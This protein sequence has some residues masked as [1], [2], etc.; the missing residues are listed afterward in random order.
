MIVFN[1]SYG[2][3]TYVYIILHMITA[4]VWIIQSTWRNSQSIKYFPS[5]RTNSETDMFIAV[6]EARSTCM[7]VARKVMSRRSSSCFRTVLFLFLVTFVWLQLHILSL[8]NDGQDGSQ[9]VND[10]TA[11]IL[12]MVPPFLHKFLTAKPRN[13]TTTGNWLI[14]QWNLKKKK[15][16]VIKSY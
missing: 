6:T 11:A 13:S 14:E 3:K 8:G 10:S 4:K 12:N 7:A 5:A 1:L 9:E 16:I 2:D 15:N